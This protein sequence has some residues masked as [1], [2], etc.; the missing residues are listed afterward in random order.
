MHLDLEEMAEDDVLGAAVITDLTWKQLLDTYTCTECGRCQSQC[1]AWA[2]GKPLSPKLLV[3][4]LRDELLQQGPKLLEAKQKS[5]E[6]YA[7]AL[8]ELPALNPRVVEDEVVWDCTTC[9]A[10]VQACP[11]NI[12]HI[13]AIVD[14]RRNL[15]MGESRFPREMQTALQNLENTGNPWGSPPQERLAW[16]EGS[17]RQEPLEIKHISDAPD[18]EIL[19]WVGCAGAF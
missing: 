18:A 4:D 9:G 14:M 2:T 15:V 10:C 8:K 7:A 5:S 3:M 17:S 6:A 19:F 11:V 13:D 16:A 1:P 12:E